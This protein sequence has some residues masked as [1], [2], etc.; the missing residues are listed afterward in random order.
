MT[1][2]IAIYLTSTDRSALSKRF[3]DYAVML[4]TLLAPHLPDTDFDPF[5]VVAGNFP[6]NPTE[7]DG[8]VVTGSAAFVSD[9][10]PWIA[11]LFDHI[12][13]LDAAHTKLLGVCFGH[14]AIAAA[15][16]GQVARR[17]IT[18][19]AQ[20]MHVH[21]KRPWMT[22]DADH[23]RLYAGN[24]EQV[25]ELPDG[26]TVLGGH[27]DCPNILIEKG[28]HILGMQCHPEFPAAFMTEYINTVSDLVSAE[29]AKAAQI[30]VDNGHDGKIF[31]KWAA[32]FLTH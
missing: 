30:E 28:T 24:F 11:T 7:F 1:R 31:G 14:Q 10:D 4:E 2:R 3:P 29:K 22:P 19:G 12:R 8:V 9:D 26:M 21:T 18:L 23:L 13:R 32:N 17:E 20:K 6:D 27:P 25:I 5:D 16:G 15:L